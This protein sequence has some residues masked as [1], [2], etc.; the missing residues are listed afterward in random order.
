[1]TILS[2]PVDLN[3]PGHYLHWGVVQISLANFV[4]ILVMIA[5]F[6]VALLLPFPKGR[7]KP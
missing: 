4:V 7:Q 5:V 3:Q 2:A 6:A 1:M